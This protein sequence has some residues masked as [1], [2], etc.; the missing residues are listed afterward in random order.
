MIDSITYVRP[1]IT[2]EIDDVAMQL[3]RFG[4]LSS[5]LMTT[6]GA[7]EGGDRDLSWVVFLAQ[8]ALSWATIAAMEMPQEAA[9]FLTESATVATE[10][11]NELATAAMASA[12]AL[13]AGYATEYTSATSVATNFAT[14]A[15]TFATIVTTSATTLA[16][17]LFLP[18][19]TITAYAAVLSANAANLAAVSLQAIAA[20]VQSMVGCN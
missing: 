5:G 8:H 11:S 19:A 1:M 3:K 10:V 20:Q 9:M 6:R 15:T 17:T 12:T 7:R 16:S 14:S 2:G 4:Q 13:A 18:E